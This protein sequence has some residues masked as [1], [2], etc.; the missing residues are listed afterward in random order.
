M[1][2]AVIVA[3]AY[4]RRKEGPRAETVI[5][6][7]AEQMGLTPLDPGRPHRFGGMHRDHAFYIDIGVTGSV[8][9]R[10]VGLSRAVAVSIEVQMRE[11]RQG[12]A[13]CNRGRVDSTSTF[14]AAFSAKLRYEWLSSSARES[15]LAFVR[16][17]EDLFL[18]GLPIHPKPGTESEAKVRLQHNIPNNQA[19]PEQVYTVLDDLIEVARVIEATC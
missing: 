19:A 14:D 17:R 12:Y 8:S 10:N 3:V 5:R 18:E 4:S 7:L 11:P 9:S 2:I 13:Y 6:Q 1:V 15:M 16:R